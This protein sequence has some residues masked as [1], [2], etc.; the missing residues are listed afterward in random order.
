MKTVS[1]GAITVLGLI[2]ALGVANQ[3]G[4]WNVPD[5]KVTTKTLYCTVQDWQ[6]LIA[7]SLAIVAALM[8]ARPVYQQLEEM[9]AQ[10]R[11][12]SYQVLRELIA[13]IENER[14]IADEIE[15]DAS[16]LSLVDGDWTRQATSKEFIA[17]VIKQLQK[18]LDELGAHRSALYQ[19]GNKK[20]GD[21]SAVTSRIVFIA[22]LANLRLE[23]TKKISSLIALNG[24]MSPGISG[25]Q[26]SSAFASVVSPGFSALLQTLKEA[27][28]KFDEQAV[29][30]IARIKPGL[31]QAVERLKIRATK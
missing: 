11:L 14:L 23:I 9:R 16:V 4:W 17:Q 15:V 2:L 5:C 10:T 3:L 8:A 18:C 20:W 27:Q 19:S 1:I 7:G 26:V 21:A 22:A 31:D 30:E 24:T 12:Q 25:Q 29:T 13:S 28:V 6:T